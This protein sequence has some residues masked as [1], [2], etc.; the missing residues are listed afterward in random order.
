MELK[1]NLQ[2]KFGS[3]SLS[4]KENDLKL[5][6]RSQIS[7]N[8]ILFVIL[9]LENS[10]GIVFAN[11]SN[12]LNRIFAF[13]HKDGEY[14]DALHP[15]DILQIQGKIKQMNIV[16]L[17]QGYVIIT[18]DDVIITDF[19][20]KIDSRTCDSRDLGVTSPSRNRKI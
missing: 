16:D 7:P 12:V 17:A 10:L 6:L 20:D 3:W 8:A 18:N 15:L 5:F 2:D 14:R 11:K 9:Q 13:L 19:K 4:D 1:T